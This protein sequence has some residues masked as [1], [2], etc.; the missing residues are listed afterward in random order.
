[1][2]NSDNQYGVCNKQSAIYSQIDDGSTALT[3]FTTVAE[4]KAFFFTD[5]ALTVYNEC[6]TE[7]QWALVGD[8]ALKFTMAFGTKG[9]NIAAADDW[10]ELFNSRKKS[11]IDTGQ[12]APGN[13]GYQTQSI[14]SHL[15]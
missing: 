12:W 7:L 10:A 11:L 15:F 6:C 13:K 1:M 3:T 14:D 2:T 4:A 5:A 9:G 8:T